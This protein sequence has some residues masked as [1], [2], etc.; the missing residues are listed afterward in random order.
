M[1][2]SAKTNSHGFDGKPSVT[3][4]CLIKK[5]DIWVCFSSLEKRWKTGNSNDFVKSHRG[6]NSFQQLLPSMICFSPS[7]RSFVRWSVRPSVSSFV[8]SFINLSD[9][10]ITQPPM[11]QSV[12]ATAHP[13]AHYFVLLSVR[14]SVR[15]SDNPSIPHTFVLPSFHDP[16]P[17]VH[18]IPISSVLPSVPVFIY[19]S[20]HSSVRHDLQSRTE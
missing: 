10:L 13:Y 11:A 2:F 3:S 15:L 16:W 6:H 9:H 19:L 4:V 12:Y 8:L 7:V 14:P 18:S 5:M 17:S 20:V 1:Y